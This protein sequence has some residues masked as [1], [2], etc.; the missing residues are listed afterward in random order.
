MGV[1]GL[2]KLLKEV[3]SRTVCL[4]NA[5]GVIV[6]DEHFELHK[7]ASDADVA[8]SLMVHDD[9]TP[10]ALAVADHLK[11]FV[12]A[13][14]DVTVVFD[15]GS[16][17]SKSRTARSRSTGR[18]R[19][20]EKLRRLSWEPGANRDDLEATAKKAVSFSTH[21][22][23][24]VVRVLR[25]VLS[26]N[27]MT[28]PYESDP[29][30]KVLDDFYEG[31]GRRVLLRGN[32]SD[33]VV[34]GV[35]NLL[36]H[37]WDGAG[38]ELFGEVI[39]KSAI[40]RPQIQVLRRTS[41][42]HDFIRRLHG[43]ENDADADNTWWSAAPEAVQNRLRLWAS[44]AGN[45]YCKFE[46]IGQGTAT[47][48]CLKRVSG[49]DPSIE[50]VISAVAQKTGLPPSEIRSSLKTSQDMVLHPVVYHPAT[51]RQAHLSGIAT[52]ADIT[53]NTGVNVLGLLCSLLFTLL[54]A[55]TLF[56][57]FVPRT[58]CCQV[59]TAVAN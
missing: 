51:G 42:A 25:C 14:W 11:C 36:H 37:D 12:S 17:P 46:N 35:S 5:C 39:E 23:A 43:V 13:G 45:D 31:Q 24:R 55:A 40:G 21:I 59:Q 54:V 53:Y 22:V 27:C 20:L 26:C 50:D 47:N 58:A 1:S 16:P 41:S 44:V 33:L 28:S 30:L 10:L 6:V 29:Q 9:V 34:L 3:A 7:C 49:E 4:S 56:V 32:D 57:W 18:A 8:I 48:I 52:S 19:A 38:G 2:L 15:G